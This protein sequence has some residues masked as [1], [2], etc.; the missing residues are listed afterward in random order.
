MVLSGVECIC[1][2]VRMGTEGRGE[3]GFGRIVSD[4][5]DTVRSGTCYVAVR[6]EIK[7]LRI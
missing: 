7:S 6:V 4:A 3:W 2:L 5:V 1:D